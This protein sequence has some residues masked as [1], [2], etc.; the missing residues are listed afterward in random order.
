MFAIDDIHVSIMDRSDIGFGRFCLF[1]IILPFLPFL[2][3]TGHFAQMAKNRPV[4]T[5]ILRGLDSL[6][7]EHTAP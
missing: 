4:M 3:K 7:D 6:A 5:P 1:L 2:G